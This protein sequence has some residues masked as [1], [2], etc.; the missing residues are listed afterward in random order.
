MKHYFILI[1]LLFSL[2]YTGCLE[3]TGNIAAA[4]R[5]V[6]N[7]K[8]PR[9]PEPDAYGIDT[10]YYT[11]VPGRIRTNQF[12]SEILDN[13]NIPYTRLDSLIRNS[14]DV[15]DIRKIK[16]GNNYSLY[17]RSDSSEMLDYM[18]YEHDI[19]NHYILDFTGDPQIR[20]IEK[21]SRFELKYSSGTIETSL[22]NTVIEN[23]LHPM[24]AIELSEIYAWSI[25]F[26]GL[27]RGDSFKLI[28]EE[29]YIDT[30]SNG[31][32]RIYGASFKHA[33]TEFYA[34]P[35]IQD[36]EES[37]YDT[38]GNSLRKAFLKAPLRY[39]RIS[40]RYS[41]NRL[42]P[43]LR[44]R[45]PHHGVDYA[46]A[47]G[48]PVLAIGDGRIIMRDYQQGAG[49]IVKIRHNS[50]YTTAYMHLSRF[51]EGVSVGKYV[52][53]GDII[54]YVGS[55]GLSTGPH[56]DFRFYKNGHAIDP[57]KVKAPPVKPVSDDN[58]ERFEKISRVMV[59]LMDTF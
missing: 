52:K 32:S 25:D 36:G 38:E 47:T 27:Q 34:I 42:H 53:Q 19:I 59:E 10:S 16:A 6:K 49:R 54:G 57:L 21:P 3:T 45:R 24:L 28:Y 35:L 4:E 14:A 51:G 40:S 41:N 56:L 22:W 8:E 58:K 26:F 1:V 23:D 11:V 50:V 17:L 44:I 48:T 33:G 39:S 7:E 12:L 18:V 2:I 20:K 37:F 13:Y 5:I 43:I 29:E 9:P 55:T 30:L 31:I 15:F 46:A